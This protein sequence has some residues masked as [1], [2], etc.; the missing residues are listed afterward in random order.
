M[1][2]TIL[3]FIMLEINKF[4]FH[5]A[6][7]ILNQYYSFAIES[8]PIS[9]FVKPID[10]VCDYPFND[11]TKWAV[12]C[13]IWG[14]LKYYH[15][16]VTAG[17]FDWDQVLI[18]R[19]EKINEAETPEQVNYELMQMIQTAGEYVLSIDTTWN[20]SLNMN[21][22]LCWLD[23]SFIDDT[24]K[25]R[26]REIASQGIY[27]PQ[28]YFR[29]KSD[30]ELPTPFEKDYAKD[31]ISRYEFRLLSLFRYWNIIYYFYPYK[32]LLDQSWDK[33]LYKFIPEFIT[34]ID[35]LSYH[36]AVNKLSTQLNDGHGYTS[37]TPIYNPLTF[38]E[39]THIDSITVIRTPPKGSILERGDII[40]SID[41][42][43]INSV[44]DS[45]IALIPSSN[46][47]FTDYAVNGWIYVSVFL[48]CNLT[49]MRNAEM[50]NIIEKRKNFPIDTDST[51]YHK[52]T[53]E[54]GFVNL[55]KLK[56]SVIPC[57]MDSL[58]NCKGVIFDLRNYPTNFKHWDIISYLSANQEYR[59]ALATKVDLSH[60]GA[61]YKYGCVT[62]C[63]DSLWQERKI[64]T[65]KK[66]VLVNAATMSWA[67]TL[68]MM[69]RIHGATL[70][71]TPTAGANGNVVRFS[72]PGQITVQ[73][74][75]LGFYYPDGTQ[76]QRT[77]IIPDIEVYPT[78]EDIMAGRDEV[79]EAAITFLN[80]N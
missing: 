1:V 2:Q 61:F 15:P 16:N 10:A 6:L 64:F 47:L 32:Y 17:K 66:V 56:N 78:M 70:I 76:T 7:I 28:Y 22:N 73:Y 49:V 57:M 20:D 45:L 46:R 67:E 48:G 51:S 37:L 35:T 11:T 29:P 8:D 60:C 75:G 3:S 58:N 50:M 24:I 72:L 27:F 21:V 9:Y 31:L 77:G 19:I 65:G 55:D 39:I 62:K 80:S 53:S 36:T 40:L 54:I 69:F 18:D 68:S 71:G 13:R 12:T 38:S 52:I 63:P 26:I 5:F 59:Y 30:S 14:L 33:T 44:R 4:I 74:S 43:S 79:L 34:A 42:K 25:Q 23:Y 41:G